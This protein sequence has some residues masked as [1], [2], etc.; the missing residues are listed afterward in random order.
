[1][2]ADWIAVSMEQVYF[3]AQIVANKEL[4]EIE[5]EVLKIMDLEDGEGKPPPP[6]A[7]TPSILSKEV[8]VDEPEM[9]EGDVS[10]LEN[11][12]PE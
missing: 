10:D 12:P 7:E 3:E 8:K 4:D 1:M 6:P 9:D 5:E 2:L 11:Y